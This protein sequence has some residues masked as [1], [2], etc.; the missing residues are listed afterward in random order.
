MKEGVVIIGLGK[1]VQNKIIPAFNNLRIPILGIVTKNIDIQ[2]DY[3]KYKD[4]N[5]IVKHNSNLKIFIAHEP[6]NHIKI[7]NDLPRNKFS[8]LLEKPAFISFKDLENN[9]NIFKI[10]EITEAMMYRFG[11]SFVKTKNFF[12]CNKEFI[13][14]IDLKF[15]LPISF[16]QIKNNFR[17]HASNKNNIIYEVGCYFYDFMWS[18][19]LIPYNLQ[20]KNIKYFSNKTLKKISASI[21][22]ASNKFKFEINFCFGYGS[23]YE[24]SVLLKTSKQSLSLS[25]FF[26]GRKGKINSEEIVHEFKKN[27]SFLQ[28]NLYE[29]QIKFWFYEKRLGL[30]ND[31]KNIERYRFVAENLN[32]LEKKVCENV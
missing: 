8:I 29:K 14:Q 25:P 13:K 24:N 23:R 16:E 22:I 9:K 28:S 31:L 30:N 20:I 7:I 18:L 11:K 3:P 4:I 5:E 12:D 32:K 6:K 1:H 27:S 17:G 10:H 15:V 19:N 26:W 21:Y 2:T